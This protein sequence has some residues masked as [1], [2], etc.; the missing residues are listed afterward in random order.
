MG[1]TAEEGDKKKQQEPSSKCWTPELGGDRESRETVIE[2]LGTFGVHKA[3]ASM[4]D[5]NGNTTRCLSGE[6]RRRYI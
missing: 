1:L 3:T 2:D 5:I 6:I 4:G